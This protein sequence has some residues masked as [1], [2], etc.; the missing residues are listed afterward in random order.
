MPVD[1]T[2]VADYRRLADLGCTDACAVPWG[3]DPTAALERQ[4]DAIKRFGD[5]IIARL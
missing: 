3:M 4:L 1:A 5:E 2:S